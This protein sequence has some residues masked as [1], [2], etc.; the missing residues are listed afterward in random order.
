MFWRSPVICFAIAALLLVSF[1]AGTA[2]TIVPSPHSERDRLIFLVVTAAGAAFFVGL[3]LIARDLGKRQSSPGQRPAGS[4]GRTKTGKLTVES[5]SRAFLV[6]YIILFALS[7]A[8]LGTPGDYVEWYVI[9][10]VC[11]VPPLIWGTLRHRV[12]T[13]GLLVVTLAFILADH[14]EGMQFERTFGEL[15]GRHEQQSKP[16]RDKPA[17]NPSE[18]TQPISAELRDAQYEKWLY[19]LGSIPVSKLGRPLRR[20]KEPLVID[21]W[22]IPNWAQSS[23]VL[24]EA[25]LKEF[26]LPRKPLSGAEYLAM[27]D[28]SVQ[29]KS[30][31]LKPFLAMKWALEA[32]YQHGVR[33]PDIHPVIAVYEAKI[34]LEGEAIRAMR[35]QIGWGDAMSLFQKHRDP[36]LMDLMPATEP[37][38]KEYVAF[39]EK[40]AGDEKLPPMARR[41]AHS[42]LLGM[43]KQQYLPAYR[44]FVVKTAKTL[45]KDAM[46]N[47][48]DEQKQWSMMWWDRGCF[49]ADLIELDDKDGWAV[50]ND[51][52][53]N[54]PVTE[55]REQALYAAGTTEAIGRTIDSVLQLLQGEGKHCKFVMPSHPALGYWIPLKDYL[56]RA[57]KDKNLPPDVAVKVTQAIRLH[58]AKPPQ[59]R[60]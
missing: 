39:L 27:L 12:I 36:Q 2:V 9:T 50:V 60:E 4:T 59:W 23:T 48:A 30:D 25:E 58:A 33:L 26:G 46:A 37:D 35:G 11:L 38:R 3:G 28:V 40:E 20:N 5:V 57:A 49:Y 17:K 19:D 10:S 53:L 47:A 29:Q 22:I 43:N 44:V 18:T 21:G 31:N 14:R 1:F 54:D 13:A 6:A 41:T 24:T 7:F 51:A 16:E 34:G 15:R 55:A 42:L 56:D 8:A 45:L 52:L 32:I